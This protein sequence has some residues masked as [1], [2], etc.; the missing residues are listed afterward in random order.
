VGLALRREHLFGLLRK[1][2]AT[3][4][5][6]YGC[7]QP[8]RIFRTQA[9]RSTP[10]VTYAFHENSKSNQL[11]VSPLGPTIVHFHADQAFS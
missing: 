7:N 11:A 5:R 10:G 6:T 1:G 4:P 9:E 3:F 2:R 8:L